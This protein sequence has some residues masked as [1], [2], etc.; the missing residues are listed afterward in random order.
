[1]IGF[2]IGT[3]CL[4]GLLKVVRH[5]RG[6][7]GGCHSGGYGRHGRHGGHEGGRGWG[8]GGW[9]ERGGFGPRMFL[10]SIFERLDTT[11]GQEKVIIAAMEE[12][13]D[14][15]RAIKSEAR[16]AR[17]DFAKAMRGESFDEVALGGATAKVEGAVD[18]MRK[19]G[20]SAFAKVHEALDDRQRQ[21]LADLM[22]HGRG[23]GPWGRHGH[24][25]D[26]HDRNDHPYRNNYSV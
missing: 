14:T 3:V 11:P 22:E 19:A 16:E 10:R 1:M 18:A 8:R 2:L 6:Y 20:I 13:K 7:G 4:I 21:Q 26:R 25:H 17:T 23:F 5:G 15:A 12:L 24:D 9:G